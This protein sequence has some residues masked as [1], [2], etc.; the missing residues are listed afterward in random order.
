MIYNV[1]TP[2]KTFA[3]T[4]KEG[5]S[6]S[7]FL[8]RIIAKSALSSDT[9][10]AIKEKKDGSGLVYEFEGGRWSLEDGMPAS[11]CV[12]H[13]LI[14]PHP[15]D[16]LEILSTRLPPKSTPSI[17]LH[18]TLP[19]AH[20]H[21]AKGQSPSP[22][23]EAIKP[24]GKPVSKLPN[25]DGG[26]PKSKPAGSKTKSLLSTTSRRSKWGDD[27]A[28]PMGEVHKRAW[29]EFQNNQGV[30]TVMGKVGNVDNVRMLL[31]AGYRHVYVSRSFAIANK[32]VPA[33]YHMGGSG[34]AGLKTLGNVSITVG[35]KTASHPAFIN[36]ESHFDVV[37]GRSWIEKMGVKTDPLDQTAL[38]YMDSGEAIP[39]DLVV[40]KDAE[41][42]V[43]YI[44]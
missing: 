13:V 25:G 22:S 39:C 20:A 27:D 23:K 14:P 35:G 36:E 17:T 44:T 8:S 43:I 6:H 21:F 18:L 9:T 26:K 40:L 24:L 34:Y 19:R 33:K 3:L 10:E 31:K 12:A 15:D 30:R 41:G 42:N 32:L 28:E 38:T 4:Y 5:E 16:D 37:L 11:L 29:L 2:S 7:A 1:H